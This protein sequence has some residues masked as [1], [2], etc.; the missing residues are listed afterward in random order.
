MS[1]WLVKRNVNG[2]ETL[3]SVYPDGPPPTRG[4]DRRDA[5]TRAQ[6]RIIDEASVELT[7]GAYALLDEAHQHVE[8]PHVVNVTLT[9]TEATVLVRCSLGCADRKVRLFIEHG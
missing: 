5:Q 2:N 9:R 1:D 3:V 4:N 8:S 7:S 6:H